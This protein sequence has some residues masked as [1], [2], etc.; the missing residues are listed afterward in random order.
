[1]Q[2]S[3]DALRQAT[4]EPRG[5]RGSTAPPDPSDRVRDQIGSQAEVARSFDRIAQALAAGTSADDAE[6]RKL[7]EQIARAQQLRDKMAAT[8]RD[9]DR[10][11]RQ[12]APS[13][14]SGQRAQSPGDAQANGAQRGAGESGKPG[15]GQQG[16]GGRGADATRLREEYLRQLQETKDLIDQIRRDDPSLAQGAG[17]GFTFEEATRQSVTAPGTEAFKQ[18]FAKWEDLRRQA[19]QALEN[20]EATLSKKL[21]SKRSK[22]RL[23]AGADDKAPPEY[24]QQVDSY[25][26]AIAKKKQ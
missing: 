3:A 11:N 2:Q 23:A 7:S 5:L 15:E 18:D 21:Q 19:T 8:S 6:S 16:G 22:D 4:A 25:F 1:M 10:A 12:G 20:I 13:G 17:L 26:K 9:L 14:R 24:K